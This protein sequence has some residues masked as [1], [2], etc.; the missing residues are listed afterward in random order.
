[1]DADSSAM[2]L[3]DLASFLMI[4][5]LGTYFDPAAGNHTAAALEYYNLGY[6]CLDQSTYRFVPTLAAIRCLHLMSVYHLA[7]NDQAGVCRAWPLLAI[8]GRMATAC[9]LHR[10]MMKRDRC[11]ARS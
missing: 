5:C 7:S 8:A 11:R 4:L 10:G 2:H 1:M 9:G 3:E 6:A